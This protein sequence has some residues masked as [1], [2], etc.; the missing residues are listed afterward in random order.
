MVSTLFKLSKT[1]YGAPNSVRQLT[2]AALL[3]A[4]ADSQTLRSQQRPP[5]HRR[6]APNSVRRLTE[7]ALPTASADSQTRR[8]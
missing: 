1:C 4:S 6:G 7:A 5:T 2:D 8:S 3:T